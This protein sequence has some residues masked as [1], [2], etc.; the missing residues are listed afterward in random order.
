[1]QNVCKPQRYTKDIGQWTGQWLAYALGIGPYKSSRWMGLFYKLINLYLLLCVAY[2]LTNIHIR[3]EL[4]RDKA[5]FCQLLKIRFFILFKYTN[6]FDIIMER[7]RH[8]SRRKVGSWFSATCFGYCSGHYLLSVL[9]VDFGHA[10]GERSLITTHRQDRYIQIT[11][12][13][14]LEKTSE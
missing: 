3:S 11:A 7:T 5:R 6:G 2:T 9:W 8:L 13:R 4:S 10:K 12:R 14:V 1:M